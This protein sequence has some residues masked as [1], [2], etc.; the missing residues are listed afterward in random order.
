MTIRARLQRLEGRAG[1]DCSCNKQVRFLRERLDA[2]GRLLLEDMDGDI[3][4][5]YPRAES[6]DLC[7]N[8]IRFIVFGSTE[9]TK[10]DEGW[11]SVACHGGAAALDYRPPGEA[12]D[13][14]GA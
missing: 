4:P 3:L 10:D 9:R 8:R 13:K 5:G 11:R 6:C 12:T 1:P 2:E 7:K 14:D